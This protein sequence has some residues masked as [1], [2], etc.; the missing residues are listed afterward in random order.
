MRTGLPQFFAASTG[1]TYGAASA[2]TAAPTADG[3]NGALARTAAGRATPLDQ[4][5]APAR[6]ADRC[7]PPRLLTGRMTTSSRT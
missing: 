2:G 5:A 1:L 7:L 3:I 4:S 6:P